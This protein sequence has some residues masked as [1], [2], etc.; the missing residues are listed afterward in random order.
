VVT[1]PSGGAKK[2]T[3]REQEEQRLEQDERRDRRNI[4]FF[5]VGLAMTP[6]QIALSAMGI[7]GPI[8]IGISGTVTIM[9]L[10]VGLYYNKLV[11]IYPQ[12]QERLRFLAHPGA[13]LGVL[14]LFV[15][16]SWIADASARWNSVATPAG[17]FVSPEAKS[18]EVAKLPIIP[19]HARLEFPVNT[20]RAIP[21]GPQE[22]IWNWASTNSSLTL[23]GIN[24][25]SQE[26]SLWSIAV[27]FTTPTN[28][29]NI[30]VHTLNTPG[31]SLPPYQILAKDSR[32][33]FVQFRG[34]LAG[35]IIDISNQP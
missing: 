18:Q 23:S 11:D 16:V 27:V 21:A 30:V 25:P 19:T 13:L 1:S 34:N 22:N 3:R 4:R 6:G 28:V 9:L 33:V 32:M 8:T 31:R 14:F 24:R 17:S 10:L 26:L 29:D 35:F 12:I 15:A 7:G 2:L 20:G 5:L